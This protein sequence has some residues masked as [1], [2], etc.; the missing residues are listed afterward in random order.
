V[1]VTIEI[2]GRLPAPLHPQLCPNQ[3]TNEYPWLRWMIT[4]VYLPM[5]EV[6]ITSPAPS[7]GAS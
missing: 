1:V 4:K 7:R 6:W 2:D 3:E 5:A